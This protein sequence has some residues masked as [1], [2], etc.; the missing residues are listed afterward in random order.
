MRVGRT[1]MSDIA[2]DPNATN[3]EGRILCGPYIRNVNDAGM[4]VNSLLFGGNNHLG[5]FFN[6]PCT[7]R[8]D[9]SALDTE[10]SAGIMASFSSA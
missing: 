7:A 6:N 8:L 4:T 1:Y 3:G 5:H 2:C 9:A 10:F